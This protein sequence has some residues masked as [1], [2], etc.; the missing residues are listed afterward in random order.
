MDITKPIDQHRAESGG[1]WADWIRIPNVLKHPS[2][3]DPQTF[4]SEAG[5][6]TI[7]AWRAKQAGKQGEVYVPEP[8]AQ[9]PQYAPS[10]ESTGGKISVD[11]P[12]YDPDKEAP[13]TDVPVAPHL[14]TTDDVSKPTPGG[15]SDTT[16]LGS[17]PEA[18][19]RDADF[20]QK[21]EARRNEEKNNL[22]E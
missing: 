8:T 11:D 14:T 16:V 19:G 21:V 15:P 9:D 17:T 6:G 3:L 1:S 20:R 22:K 18:Q 5:G 12:K 13:Q 2:K 7:E 4:M 10:L